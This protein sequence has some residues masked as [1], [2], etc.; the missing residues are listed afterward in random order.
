MKAAL[1]ALFYLEVRTW[2]NRL[3]V[4]ARDPKR[5]VPWVI[6]LAWLT[7]SQVARII[8]LVGGHASRAP[9]GPAFHN[10]AQVV[11]AAVPGL[12]VVLIGIVVGASKA[13]PADF[14]S[15]ADARFLAGSPMSQRTVVLWLQVRKFLNPR[16]VLSLFIGT[17]LLALYAVPIANALILQLTVFAAVLGVLGLQLPLFLARSKVRRLPWT[18]LT[19]ALVLAGLAGAGIGA[20]LALGVRGFPSEWNVLKLLPPGSVVAAGMA[21]DLRALAALMVLAGLS[22]G[23][24]VFVAGDSYPELWEASR[25]RFT[26]VSAMRR[27][28]TLSRSEVR[29]ALL[30]GRSEPDRLEIRQ[31]ASVQGARVPPGAMTVVWKEWMAMRRRRGGIGLQVVLLAISL[32]A[33]AVF[34]LM[35]AGGDRRAGALV[36]GFAFPLVLASAYF[37]VSLATDLRNPLWWLSRA[38]LAQRLAAWTLAGTL[39]YFVIIGAGLG[40]ALALSEPPDVAVAGLVALFAG[41][42]TMRAVGLAVY[43][44]IPSS[45]DMV[46]PGVMIRVLAIYLLSAP[47]FMAGITAGFLARSIT[48]GLAAGSAAALAESIGLLALATNRIQGN[49][50]GFARAETR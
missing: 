41:I 25:R 8:Y 46:G 44:F 7:I 22:L 40:V 12:Y 48:I 2:I 6:F 31:A 28:G 45:L 32:L 19:W 5:L 26:L 16:M 37:R 11:L 21:G 18:V 20:S 9:Q 49:G 43:A 39:P 47:P 35:L 17:A 10:F 30:E 42:W 24:A 33:G 29:R 23:L 4:L 50:L 1:G 34:G 38:G 15:P 13:A 36:G 3:R 27:R 14:S